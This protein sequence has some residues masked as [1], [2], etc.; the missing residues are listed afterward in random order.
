MAITNPDHVNAFTNGG[1]G[2]VITQVLPPWHG[3]GKFIL[4]LVALSCIQ[5]NIVN[6]Y[7]SGRSMQA[8]GR[9]LAKSLRFVSTVL[10]FLVF[11]IADVRRSA[12]VE[13][14]IDQAKQFFDEP[15]DRKMQIDI[16]KTANFKGYCA[17]LGENADPENRG[18]MHEAFN[19]GPENPND[20]G[21]M[22]GLNQWPIDLPGFKAPVLDL[23]NSLVDLGKVIFHLFALALDLPEDFFDDKTKNAAAVMRL[24]HYPPQT[25]IVDDR[26]VGIGAHTDYECFTILWQDEVPAL[27]VLNTANQWIDAKPIPGTLVLNIGDQFARWTNDIFKSTRHRVINRS[28]VRRYSVPLFF[29]TDYDV[30]LEASCFQLQPL[31][32]L[33]KIMLYLLNSLTI[34]F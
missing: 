33:L 29:G 15:L 28:G 21:T 18:D 34:R 27:Q 26:V 25:G 11:I 7:S 13:K 16:H 12:K 8:I 5:N 30:K 14:A 1:T 9:P 17:L 2:G 32:R 23:Y 22:R 6:T 20:T 24:L 10:M 19:I 3:F 31:T 4:V